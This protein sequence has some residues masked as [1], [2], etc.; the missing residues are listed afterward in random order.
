MYM[1]LVYTLLI[2]IISNGIGKL[3]LKKNNKIYNLRVPIGFLCFLG[4]L[5]IFYYPLQFFHLSSNYSFYI[6]SIISIVFLIIGITKI[7]KEDFQFLKDY[8]F[9][10]LLVFFFIVMRIIPS[11]DATDDEFYFPFIIDNAYN[12]INFIHPQT[13]QIYNMDPLHAYQGYYLFASFLYRIQHTLFNSFID[14]FVSFRATFTL[15][16]VIY[17]SNLLS[18]IKEKLYSK[19][20][21]YIY[22]VLELLSVLLIGIHHL[23][24]I[25]Y[26]SFVLFSIY[27][28]ILIIIYN[29]YLKE[30]N[31]IY[32]I[33][34][35]LSEFGLLSFASSSLFLILILL[36]VMFSYEVI[37]NKKLNFINYIVFSIST[38]IYLCFI[39][40][41]LYMILLIPIIFL[42]FKKFNNSINKFFLKFGK[43]IMY[44]V[45]IVFILGS[46]ILGNIINLELFSKSI[47][48]F[49]I[50][51]VF[52]ILYLIFVKKQK[53][54]FITFSYILTVIIFYNPLTAT[55]VS[56]YFTTEDVFYRISFITKN[57]LVIISIFVFILNALKN[58]KI[59]K[60]GIYLLI[61][62][63][64][65]IYC[66]NIYTLMIK[67][68][69][70][71]YKYDYI[72]RES[73]EN[74]DLG[75]KI[76]NISGN[77]V[78]LDYSVRIYNPDLKVNLYRFLSVNDTS[79][80]VFKVLYHNASLDDSF[81][82]EIKDYNYIIS[83]NKYNDN[84]KNYYECIYSNKIYSLYKIGGETNDRN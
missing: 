65:F 18:F 68:E 55:F 75:E 9:W 22:Y 71:N 28:P 7:K 12:S 16:F 44:I 47:L 40:N 83:Q 69:D 17:F 60:Y 84:L 51:I 29:N 21:K 32:I 78:S 58:R 33:M 72:L 2:Y 54:N 14:I 31:N 66:K 57:P 19:N 23:N 34:T 67:N 50:S 8:H 62:G 1:F 41:K 43:Y 3:F 37:V 61:V 59:Y 15:L 70:Y 73:Y 48:L 46:V 25:Y 27:I 56:K 4:I 6:T 74:L 45:P 82:E 5:Q 76:T 36:S 39:T 52:L 10:L 35:L 63:L 24:H 80:S 20:N 79:D 26:G 42:I 49:N 13:G 53:T 38:L 81:F 64:A 30:K 77:V 11:I